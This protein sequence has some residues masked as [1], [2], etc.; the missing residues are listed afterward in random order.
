MKAIPNLLVAITN[1]LIGILIGVKEG[2]FVIVLVL[3]IACGLNFL[4]FFIAN[5]RK[6]LERLLKELDK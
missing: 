5:S 6:N 2:P 4:M 3:G 1:L